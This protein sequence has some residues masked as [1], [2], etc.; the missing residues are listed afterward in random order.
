MFWI[1][2]ALIVAVI[3]CLLL[4]YRLRWRDYVLPNKLQR[5]VP[6]RTTVPR[7]T[8]IVTSYNQSV[9]LK[10]NLPLF[11]HQDYPD[12]DIIVADEASTDTTSDVIRVLQ[13]EFPNLRFVTIPHS[14]RHVVRRQLA[15]ALAFRAAHTPWVIL[16]TADCIPS[17][18]GWLTEF[19]RY[20]NDDDTD[21]VLGYA[22]YADN[23]SRWARRAIYERLRCQLRYARATIRGE[24]IGADGCCMAV[25]R[26]AFLE[27]R[28]FEHSLTLPFGEDILLAQ[29]IGKKGSIRT[30]L[31]PES[32]VLQ[33]L[34]P[35]HQL[36]RKRM[37]AEE[38]RHHSSRRTRRFALREAMASWLTW[39]AVGVFIIYLGMRIHHVLTLDTYSWMW[40]T[41]DLPALVLLIV[42]IALP[43]H[44]FHKCCTVLGERGFCGF[45]LWYALMQPLRGWKAKVARRRNRHQ[46]H[47]PIFPPLLS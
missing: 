40:L 27:Q 20:L 38:V 1:P 28:G 9:R 26:A 25:R 21:L 41:T 22:N 32:T 13:E 15:I 14:A 34:P 16:T 47:R 2:Y 29:R 44:L 24:A 6:S 12:Y 7:I 23:G 3:V 10:E 30:V 37:Y 46:F 17:G 35:H 18:R 19:A 5:I 36:D 11:L 43:A 39:L 31:T 4:L 33:E 8:L 42:F 45:H